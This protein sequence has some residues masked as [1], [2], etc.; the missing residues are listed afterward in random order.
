MK[1][2]LFA[3]LLVAIL[4]LFTA[5]A[6]ADDAAD[7]AYLTLVDAAQQSPAAADWAALRNAYTKTSF[8]A[9]TGGINKAEAPRT[10]LKNLQDKKTPETEAA[11]NQALRQ[12]YGDVDTLLFVLYADAQQKTGAINTP[13]VGTALKGLLDAVLATGTGKSMKTAFKTITLDE[14]NAIAQGIYRLQLVGRHTESGHGRI[15]STLTVRDAQGP[16]MEM[17]FDITDRWALAA[18]PDHAQK[19]APFVLPQSADGT[20]TAD[21]AYLAMVDAAQKNAKTVNWDKMRKAYA[22]TSFYAQTGPIGATALAA[23]MAQHDVNRGTPESQDSFKKVYR[24]HFAAI[25]VQ[26][27]ADDLKSRGQADYINGTV[28]AAARKGLLESVLKSGDGK[29]PATAFQIVTGSEI[30]ESVPALLENPVSSGVVVEGERVLSRFK[31]KDRKTG[32]NTEYVFAMQGGLPG[33]IKAVSS[34]SDKL[35][36]DRSAADAKYLVLA[37]AAIK[38]PGMV[39]YAALRMAYAQTSFYSPYGGAFLTEKLEKAARDA[40]AD[41]AKTADYQTLARAH[42][43]H[44]ASHVHALDLAQ[45]AKPAFIDSAAHQKHL[46][47]I[48]ASIQKNGDGKTP[49]TAFSVIDIQEEYMLMKDVLKVQGKKRPTL[50][51]DGHVFDVFDYTGADGST[52]T[53][54]FN[55]DQIFARDPTE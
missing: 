54:Y 43:G 53:V 48:I 10:A 12:Y 17:F 7:T 25:G 47:G 26:T 9:Q 20:T 46:D 31:G 4:P 49:E 45:S 1:H 3:L 23:R 18:N 15:Y 6:A 19:P 13:A 50:Q 27:I 14:E 44:F 33:M 42:L 37:E 29:T 21:A 41:P 28:T 55:V 22:E 39:D 52:G 36:K 5:P 51:K 38:A 8:Y 30:E 16:E 2:I 24:Q 40:I 32:A 34:Q 11:F 35:R